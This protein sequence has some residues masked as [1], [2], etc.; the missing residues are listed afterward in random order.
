MKKPLAP[1][2]GSFAVAVLVACGTEPAARVLSPR[3]QDMARLERR[4]EQDNSRARFS[5]WSAPTNVG[6]PV[7]TAFAEQTPAISKDGL[8]LYFTCMNCPGGYGANDIWVAERARV[9][10][11]WGTP[12]NLGPA[13]NTAFDDASPALSRDGHLLFFDSSR[14]E[15]FGGSDIY[16]AR[17][18]HQRDNLGWQPAANLGSGINTTANESGA[19]YFAGNENEVDGNF[20]D[21]A[22]ETATLYFASN[23]VGGPGLGDIYTI[24]LHPDGTFGTA[25]LA[26]GLSSS[27]RDS[28]PTISR[29]GL[30]IYFV[31]ER[32]GGISPVDIWVSTRTRSSDAWST[33]VNLGQPING[34]GNDAGPALSFDGKSLYFHSSRPGNV[35][36]LQFF[37]LLVA[38]R[39]KLK[40]RD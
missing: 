9:D 29:D 32:P 37:D 34:A 5:E 23:R 20:E 21:D 10:D 11:P 33:P 8:S 30:E 26:E 16:V 27:F 35:G 28:G 38:T 4:A 31:S 12:Q 7:N 17:R 15:G 3:M 14:P 39:E 24:A 6:P 18:H 13:I 2:F 36:G 22:G 19:E 40:G 1:T 25:A